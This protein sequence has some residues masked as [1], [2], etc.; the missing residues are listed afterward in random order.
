M[1]CTCDGGCAN[2]KNT[3]TVHAPELGPQ[4]Y[5]FIVDKHLWDVVHSLP[6]AGRD[7]VLKCTWRRVNYDLLTLFADAP[8]MALVID[9]G[10]ARSALFESQ[11]SAALFF[12]GLGDEPSPTLLTDWVDTWYVNGLIR[13]GYSAEDALAACAAIQSG[14]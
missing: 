14:D 3:V 6:D 2:C 5:R 11:L 1:S 4:G 13:A 10:G 9:C 12:L 8:D 7:L